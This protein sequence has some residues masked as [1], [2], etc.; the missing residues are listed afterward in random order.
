M[1]V[2]QCSKGSQPHQEVEVGVF[3]CSKGSQPPQEVEVGVFPNCRFMEDSQ[4]CVFKLIL[5]CGDDT[6]TT[7]SVSDLRKPEANHSFDCISSPSLGP[8]P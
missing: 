6:L 4:S 8:S 2:F 7:A 1:G 5:P 3:Q